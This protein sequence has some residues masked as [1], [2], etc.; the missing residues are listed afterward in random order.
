MCDLIK[1]I[2]NKDLFEAAGK[3]GLYA[4]MQNNLPPGRQWLRCGLAGKPRDSAT[5][6]TVKEGNFASRFS[7]YIGYWLPT[8]GKVFAC[9]TVEA[10]PRKR[11]R[12]AD[13]VERA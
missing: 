9:L 6:V 11:S 7:T 5:D 8:S 4:I 13:A 12:S 3:P 1:F 2:T 10:L